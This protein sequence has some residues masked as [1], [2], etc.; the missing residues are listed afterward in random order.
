[1]VVSLAWLRT[2]QKVVMSQKCSQNKLGWQKWLEI[3]VHS[4][5]YLARINCFANFGCKFRKNSL[6]EARLNMLQLTTVDFV[7][8]MYSVVPRSPHFYLPLAFTI[9]HGSGMTGEEWGRP[10]SIHHVSGLG[11]EEP[12]FKYVRTNLKASFLPVNTSSFRHA[13]VWIPKTRWRARTDCLG[14]GP[15]ST[16]TSIPCL[17]DIIHVMNAPR[18]SLF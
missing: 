2:N 10:R 1:M 8:L 9:I 6:W 14:I 17:P 18:P 7:W 15:L 5:C 12:I 4:H 3:C 11:G 13:K 16:P